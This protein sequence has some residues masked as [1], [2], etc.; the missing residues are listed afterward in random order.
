M[1]HDSKAK[2]T[3][4]IS[5]LKDSVIGEKEFVDTFFDIFGEY[6]LTRKNCTRDFGLI[7]EQMN[8]SMTSI[9]TPQKKGW[10]RSK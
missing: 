2:N 1:F 7:S 3:Q 8:K 10:G 4:R 5:A 9:Q 6:D